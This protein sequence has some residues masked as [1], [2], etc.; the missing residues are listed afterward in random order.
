VKEFINDYDYEDLSQE[1][2]EVKQMLTSFISK[3]QA[4]R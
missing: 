3:L 2:A 1:T 4:D